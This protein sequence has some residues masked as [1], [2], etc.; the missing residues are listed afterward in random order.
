MG[1]IVFGMCILGSQMGSGEFR[2]RAVHQDCNYQKW[3]HT[4]STS[5]G[6][7]CSNHSSTVSFQDHYIQFF[8]PKGIIRP[9]RVLSSITQVQV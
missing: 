1:K 6:G 4:E 8:G 9:K 2:K 3:L 7:E 5:S